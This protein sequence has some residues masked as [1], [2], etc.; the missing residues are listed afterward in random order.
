MKL[1]PLSTASSSVLGARRVK[2]RRE[3]QETGQGPA[4]SSRVQSP[5][6]SDSRMQ[7]AALSPKGTATALMSPLERWYWVAH[8]LAIVLRYARSLCRFCRGQPK[9][10]TILG[11]QSI[12]D[13]QPRFSL[14]S[15]RF[16]ATV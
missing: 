9:W 12:A 2:D 3:G 10:R 13:V 15:L 6:V 16:R 14:A 11:S 1:G 7:P 8:A 5:R 4:D